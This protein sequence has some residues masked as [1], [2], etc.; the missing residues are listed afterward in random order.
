MDIDWA[1]HLRQARRVVIKLGTNTVTDGD[2]LSL[3]RMIP[4]ARG[5]ADAQRAGRQIVLVSSGAVGLGAAHLGLSRARLKDLATKQA[6]AAVGQSRLMHAYEQLFYGHG[7]RIAQLLLTESDF[8]NRP[9]YQNL[10]RTMERL[11]KLGVVPVVNENDTVSTAELETVAAD[12]RRVFSDND[13][14]A[15][16]VMS[17]LDAEALILLTNVDGLRAVADDPATLIPVV[18]EI[19]PEIRARAAGPAGGGRG[20]MITK[21]EA[22]QIAQSAGGVAIIANGATAGVLERIFA[23]ESVGTVFA[24][25]TRLAGKKRWIAFATNV[26]ARLIINDGAKTALLGGKASLLSS[27]IIRVENDFAA[28]DVVSIVDAE[29]RELARGIANCAGAEWR[30]AKVLVTRDNI[31]LREETV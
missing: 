31:V 15:A 30:Q 21:L 3:E 18:E 2:G 19:T 1:K 22:A 5:V 14:L 12:G 13:R 11:L 28:Q 27:G 23:G 4:L 6:C 24:P 20:G 7:V 8:T 25:S 26:R 10:R 29:G 9:R 16:L 17:H